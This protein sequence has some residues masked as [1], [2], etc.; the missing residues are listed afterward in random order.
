MLAGQTGENIDVWQKTGLEV[1]PHMLL[2]WM[3]GVRLVY[4]WT[5]MGF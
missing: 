3:Y 4:L 5:A 2:R 1:I